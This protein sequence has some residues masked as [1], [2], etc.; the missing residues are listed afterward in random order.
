VLLEGDELA[1]FKAAGA[2]PVP[3]TQTSWQEIYRQ[4]VG[5]PDSDGCMEMGLNYRAVAQ[6]LPRHNQ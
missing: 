5:Q 2:Q 4:T 3:A 6:D 1:R